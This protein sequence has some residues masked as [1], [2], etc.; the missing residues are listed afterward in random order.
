MLSIVLVVDPSVQHLLSS[1]ILIKHSSIQSVEISTYIHVAI[2]NSIS[3]LL[4]R[5]LPSF[6]SQ[7]AAG[8]EPGKEAIV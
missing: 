6:L 8:E 7:Y 4:P 1:S 3:S 2:M 5:L